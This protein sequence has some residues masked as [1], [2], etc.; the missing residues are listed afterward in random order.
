[1]PTGNRPLSGRKA[2]QER[3]QTH[4]AC[5]KVAVNDNTQDET[6]PLPGLDAAKRSELL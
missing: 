5:N 6:H 2:I 3:R 1:M 4:I